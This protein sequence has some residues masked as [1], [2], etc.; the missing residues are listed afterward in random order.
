MT[1]PSQPLP[2]TP[3]RAALADGV[4]HLSAVVADWTEYGTTDFARSW[5]IA[6][7]ASADGRHGEP[8]SRVAGAAVDE[9]GSWW[10]WR[11]TVPTEHVG[12]AGTWAECLTLLLVL[13][14]VRNEALVLGDHMSTIKRARAGLAGRRQRGLWGTR[15]AERVFG[16]LPI[17]SPGEPGRVRYYDGHGLHARAHRIARLIRRGGEHHMPLA[18]AGLERNCAAYAAGWTGG[19]A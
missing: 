9:A 6:C 16:R 2:L 11:A 1:D 5:V 8:R 15:Q 13:R 10:A 19:A 3:G 18:G 7:D 14:R 17:I 12:L 4:L